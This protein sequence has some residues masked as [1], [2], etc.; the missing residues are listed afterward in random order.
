MKNIANLVV[1]NYTGMKKR[2]QILILFS[3]HVIK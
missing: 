3:N 1:A 2:K